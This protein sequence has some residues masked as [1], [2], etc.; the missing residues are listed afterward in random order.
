M[1]DQ[2]SIKTAELFVSQGDVIIETGSIG[3]CIVIALYDEENKVGGMAHAML[4]SRKGPKPETEEL[5]NETG[6]T[7]ARY[8]DEAIE[9]LLILIR[10]EGGKKE[11][12]T[13]KLIGG[14]SMF[15]KLSG[16]NLGMGHQ[17]TEAARAKLMFHGIRIEKEDVGG[18]SGKMVE[19]NL[20]NGVVEVN[21]K[22]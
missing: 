3:S 5:S 8:A 10:Q 9:N 21:T 1:S 14:A 16:D 17:N 13:A 22:L 19:F 2:I 15:K 6:N 4:P 20:A 18:S 11:N 7:S 12:L